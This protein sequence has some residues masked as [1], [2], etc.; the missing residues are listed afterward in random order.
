MSKVVKQYDFD[1]PYTFDGNIEYPFIWKQ[2]MC[3][4]MLIVINLDLVLFCFFVLFLFLFLFLFLVK[5]W[6]TSHQ[7]YKYHH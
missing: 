7:N 4:K 6:F 2:K 1:S 5:I 3:K